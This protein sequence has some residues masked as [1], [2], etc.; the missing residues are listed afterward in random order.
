MGGAGGRHGR[1]HK[2][3][4]WKLAEED[5]ERM[6]T[7]LPLDDVSEAPRPVP[8]MVHLLEVNTMN[9]CSFA[10]CAGGDNPD[11]TRFDE[12]EEILM[13]VPNTLASE[14]VRSSSSHMLECR[15]IGS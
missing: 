5:E 15:E 10:A 6:S 8:W 1:D 3:I 9:F 7:A 11:K 14:A 2:L 4:V 12:A 13:A